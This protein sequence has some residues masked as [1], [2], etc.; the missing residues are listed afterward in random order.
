MQIV[1]DVIK[2]LNRMQIVLDHIDIIA[3]VPTGSSHIVSSMSKLGIYIYFH[4]LI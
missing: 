2:V 3:I 1:L 4:D